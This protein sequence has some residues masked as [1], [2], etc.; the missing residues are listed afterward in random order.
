MA[1][2]PDLSPCDYFGLTLDRPLLAV[3]WL[4]AEQ[5]FAVGDP[6][7]DV[8][9]RVKRFQQG[10]WQPFIFLG[11]H[12]CELCR[13]DGC[14]SHANLFIPGSSVTYA[15][16]EAIVHYIACH[17]YSPPEEFC[18]AVLEAPEP[19]S[20]EYFERLKANGW[21]PDVAAPRQPS[22]HEVRLEA[23]HAIVQARGD[24][25]CAALDAFKAINGRYPGTLN[26]AVALVDDTLQWTYIPEGDRYRISGDW[27]AV[28]GFKVFRDSDTPVWGTACTWPQ[29]DEPAPENL[30]PDRDTSR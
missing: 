16:P 28:E 22:P 8:Y 27:M 11:V 23:L 20:P 17:G 1:F 4:A 29:R 26:E 18:R 10:R 24:A 19:D 15:A 30:R 21:P 6:G 5:P 12:Q 9:E 14:A 7:P 25:L 2:Y 3:G 13:Y